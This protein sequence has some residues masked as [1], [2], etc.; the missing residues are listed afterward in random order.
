MRKPYW[1]NKKVDLSV[2]REIK[3]MLRKLHV[4]T[5]C[6]EAF[7]P[8]ISECFG[9]KIA[10]FMILGDTCTR[11]CAF[12]GVKK[13]SPSP[14]D[15]TQPQKVKEAVKK[16]RL[17]YVVITS[18]TRD[19]LDDGGASIFYSTVKEI[20][21]LDWVKKVEV[22]IPDFGGSRD[23]IKKV[24]ESKPDVISH[25]LETVPSLYLRVRREADYTRSLKVLR[26]VKEL[27]PKIFTKSAIMLGLGEKEWEVK[28]VLED[29]RSVG[30]DFLS[31]GQYLP[32]SK[33]H[34]P[35]QYI[36]LEKFLFWGKVGLQLGFK[37]VKSSPY[38]RSSYFAHT[39]FF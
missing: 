22:L 37:N 39:Y 23:S 1:L 13:G 12:C 20:K 10:T 3:S 4:N 38:I 18:P 26:L 17:E 27:N 33:T 29:L 15:S 32:P 14:P 6:E 24:V 2:L 9:Q 5:V 19:D 34:Y 36:P 21:S 31:V 16:L 25:N 30:C 28:K 35:C 11:N 7:C 8:N